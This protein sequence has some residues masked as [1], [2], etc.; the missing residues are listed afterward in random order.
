MDLRDIWEA[1]WQSGLPFQSD[2][3]YYRPD[4]S[5]AETCSFDWEEIMF[6]LKPTCSPRVKARQETEPF[7]QQQPL[8]KPSLGVTVR[9]NPIYY[10]PLKQMHLMDCL[11]RW[12]PAIPSIPD[13]KHYSSQQEMESISLPF[14]SGLA[15]DLLWLK[16]CG[17]SYVVWLLSLSLQKPS[18][19]HPCSLEMLPSLYRERWF[20]LLV[21]GWLWKRAES[22]DQDNCQACEQGHWGQPVSCLMS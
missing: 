14:G 21:D 9:F 6:R 5:T 22:V 15:P 13:H 18:H 4:T 2:G 12:P 20:G 17:G 7:H 10:L 1:A 11:Q 16:E 19:Q 8:P 3:I